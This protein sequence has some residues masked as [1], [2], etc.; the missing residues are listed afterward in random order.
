MLLRLGLP[1]PYAPRKIRGIR[2]RGRA[3]R[4]LPI[5]GIRRAQNP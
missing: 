1:R 3:S 2:P 4:D 5:Q